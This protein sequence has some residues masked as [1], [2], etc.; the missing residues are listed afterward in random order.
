MVLKEFAAIRDAGTWTL[1]DHM[2][3]IHNIVGCWFILQ[4]KCGADG[5]VTFKAHLIAQGFSQQEGI[6]YSETFSPVIKSASQQVFLAICAHHG[7]HVRQMDIKS[8]YLNGILSEDI[9][10]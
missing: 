2:P 7:W 1:V 10:M 8:A 6:D 5:N 3:G 9:Y 4:K